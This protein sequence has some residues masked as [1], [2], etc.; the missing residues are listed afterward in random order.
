MKLTTKNMILVSL[1]TGLTAIG[2]SISIPVG[3]VSI[4][5]QSLFVIL[6]GHIL[7][8]KLGPLS[9]IVYLILGLI[10]LPIFAGFTGGLQSIMKPSFGFIISFILASYIVGKISHSKNKFNKKR[11]Y[12]ASLAGSIVMYLVGIP[13]MYYMINIIM[14]KAF[15]FNA[16][17]QMGCIL[18]LPGDL[19]KLILASSIAGKI[20][21]ILNKN[22][23]IRL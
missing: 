16:I 17:I 3:E 13:Y 8:P 22:Q 18:F 14:G 23:I 4:T 9:Q 1:F 12:L 15:S 5:M 2:A 10:G 20:L 7:G 11:I 21:P 6:S 19:L